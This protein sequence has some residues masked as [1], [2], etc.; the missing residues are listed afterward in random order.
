[1]VFIVVPIFQLH[2]VLAL[3]VFR[4]GFVFVFREVT[5]TT[6]ATASCAVLAEK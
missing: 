3:C 2:R 4:L 1:M 6:V 5:E